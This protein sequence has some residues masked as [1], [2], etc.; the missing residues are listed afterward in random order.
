MGMK[1]IKAGILDDKAEIEKH[2]PGAELYGQQR[3]NWVKEVDSA[4]Q[5]S[6]MGA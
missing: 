2:V 6:G 3:V 4:E 1:V 5:K